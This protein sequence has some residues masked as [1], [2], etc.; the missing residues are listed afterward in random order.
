MNIESLCGVLYRAYF[1]LNHLDNKANCW[2]FV[3]CPETNA[4]LNVDAY[5]Y[6]EHFSTQSLL[7]V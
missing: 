3:Y 5:L 6:S 7:H 4:Q 2:I 1:V